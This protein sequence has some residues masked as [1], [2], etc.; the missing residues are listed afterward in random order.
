MRP[1]LEFGRKM[2]VA[3]NACKDI[4]HRPAMIK[5]IK[6][7]RLRAN[8]YP[9]A[10]KEIFFTP[11]SESEYI[12]ILYLVNRHTSFP[13]ESAKAAGSMEPAV[14]FQVVFRVYLSCI[15]VY[16]QGVLFY[17]QPTAR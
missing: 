17:V 1:Y 16:G 15:Q 3:P 9:R 10:G 7:Q 4:Y 5:R 8:K 11:G 14:F 2:R 6:R 13:L 12:G